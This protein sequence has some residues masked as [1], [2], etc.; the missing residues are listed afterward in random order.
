M[1][2]PSLISRP[3]KTGLART[4]IKSRYVVE[5]W[6]GARPLSSLFCDANYIHEKVDLSS[7]SKFNMARQCSLRKLERSIEFWGGERFRAGFGARI[8][9]ISPIELN[10]SVADLIG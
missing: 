6:M 9:F 10:S 3:A 1:C 5:I 2:L 8:E 7:K 4:S